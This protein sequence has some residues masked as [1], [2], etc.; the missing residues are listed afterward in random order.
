MLFNVERCS[1]I[2]RHYIKISSFLF[3]ACWL[4]ACGGIPS[5]G[6]LQSLQSTPVYNTQEITA[7]NIANITEFAQFSENNA[8]EVAAITFTPD[9]QTLLAAYAGE[10]VLRHWS[11]KDSDLEL[12]TDIHPVNPGAVSFDGTGSKLVTAAGW[13]WEAHKLNDDYLGSRVWDTKTG[14]LILRDGQNRFTPGSLDGIRIVI[15]AI[16]SPDGKWLLESEA[17]AGEDVNNFK[18]FFQV[19]VATGQLGTFLVDFSRHRE[20]DDFDVIA[21]DFQGEFFAAAGETGE[22]D[23]F[24]FNPPEYPAKPFDTIEEPGQVGDRPLALAF[25]QQRQW[26]ARVKGN[27][28]T[29]WNLRSNSYKH[30]LD[31][32]IGEAVGPTASLAFN[33]SGTLL[34]VGTA[35]GW[36]IW[37]VK[38][39]VLLAENTDAEVYA[40]AFSPDGRLFACGDALGVINIWG[41]SE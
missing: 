8:G 16:I 27:T 7:E 39:R 15:D 37:D 19:E 14:N 1:M 36:Q 23:I 35:N 10:G 11:L 13:A 24:R 38:N 18:H 17:S 20:E 30:Q 40:V 34:G 22:V 28:L 33:P 41:I 12:T 31:V 5:A 26:L 3:L 25:D 6:R 21:F 4:T 9:M 32:S 29:I 2:M